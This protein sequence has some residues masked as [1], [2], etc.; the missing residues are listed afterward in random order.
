[1]VHRRL[2]YVVAVLAAVV[3]SSS[4]GAVFHLSVFDEVMTSYGG[5][6]NVQFIEIR[7]LA[8]IQNAVQNSV[9]AAFDNTGT[10]INDILV[11]PGNLTNQ[12]TDVRWLVGTSAF[13]TATGLAPDFIM[14]TGILP[15]SGGMVCYG[16]GGGL[17][18]A[19]PGSWSRT[20]FANYVD[21]VAYGTY[22]GSTNAHIGTP[23]TLNGDGH[24]LQRIGST[25]NNAADF[26]CADPATPENNA[27]VSANMAATTPCPAPPGPCPASPDLGCVGGFGKGMLQI[28]ED[29]G[30]EAWLAKFLKGPA[31]AQTDLGNPLSAGGTEYALCVYDNAGSLVGT[32]DVDRAGDT[33]S[34]SPCWKAVGGDPPGGKG[35]KY[36]DDALAASGVFKILYK[37]GVAGKSK[38]IVKGRGTGLPMNVADALMSATSTTLQFRS[39]DAQCL[40]VSLATIKKQEA[41]FFKA[42]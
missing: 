5:D 31:L 17:V 27:G 4:A 42:K 15:T 24:S 28:K 41:N 40:S 14:P 39:S 2:A 34:G 16:G 23:T 29:P 35:Y 6:P 11:V 32:L 26:T 20:N 10:Y 36:K 1:M 37:G 33:C 12:G 9:L 30:K 22:A 13:A 38:V 3:W 19:A 25:N 8:P 21:C 18:P 7:M